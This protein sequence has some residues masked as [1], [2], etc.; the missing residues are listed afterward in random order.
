MAKAVVFD[1]RELG[2][3]HYPAAVLREQARFVER[4]GEELRPLVERMVEVMVEE[5][6]IGLAAPQVGVSLR[7]IVVSLTGEPGD[8]KGYVNPELSEFEGVSELEEGCL[9]VPGVWAKLRR[10]AR[11]RVRAEDLEGNVVEMELEGMNARV[12]QHEVDHLNGV[13]FIDRLG[14]VAKLGVRRRLR[15]LES[16]GR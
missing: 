3:V 16:V 11:C 5:G 4:S 12:F 14:S 2:I 6:G 8:A 13:L 1:G 10:P 9:S 7:V 15:Q